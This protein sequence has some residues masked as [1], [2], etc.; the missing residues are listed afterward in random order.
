[1]VTEPSGCAERLRCPYHG[2]TYA[3]DGELKSTPELE[4][5]RCF[6]RAQNGLVPVRVE[7][8][9]KLVFGSLD[10]EAGPLADHLGALAAQVAPL[11]LDRL[12]FAERRVYELK[13]NWKVFVD[14]YLDG[15][16]HVPYL[17]RG[18]NSI[19][20]FKDYTIENFDRFCL[21]SSPIDDAGGE[22]MTASV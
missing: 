12:H 16:Y 14:N 8:W 7:T 19:L 22:A 13:C 17:H 2:W 4:G 3:L 11:G 5:I 1:V 15:G 10:P 20:S 6:D 18:L 21:Q 9:E